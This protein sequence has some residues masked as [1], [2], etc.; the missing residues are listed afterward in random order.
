MRHN[1]APKQKYKMRLFV[2]FMLVAILNVVFVFGQ[3]NYFNNDLRKSLDYMLEH[4]DKRAVPTGLLRDYAVEDEDLDI[5]SGDA[6]LNEANVAT[7]ARYGNLL[8]TIGSASLLKDLTKD[9]EK[10]LQSYYTSGENNVLSLSIMLYQYARIKENALNDELIRYENGQVYNS[11]KKESPYQTAYAFAGCCLTGTTYQSNITFGLPASLLFSNCDIKKIEIDYGSG[12]QPIISNNTLRATL[13]KGINKLILKATLRDGKELL[14]HTIVEVMDSPAKT[15]AAMLVRADAEFTVQGKD[16]RGITTAADVSIAYATGRYS[17]RK[18]L[19]IVEGF[20]P[21]VFEDSPK[22][23]WNFESNVSEDLWFKEMNDKLGYDIVYVDW[24]KSEEYIQANANTLIEV[25]N[26]VNELKNNADSNEPNVIMGHSMGGLITRYALKTMENKGIRHQT[27]T[28]VSYDAPH[29][30]AHVPLGVLYGFHGMLSFIESRGIVKTLLTNNPTF[31]SYLNLGKSMAYATSAQ[32]M[33]AYFVDPAGHFNNQEHIHWQKEI[34]VLG[35]PKGDVGLSFTMLAVANGS[36][37]KPNI[38]D[39]YLKTDFS[40]GSDVASSFF[41]KLSALAVGIGLND[42]VSGFLTLLPG[43]TAINGGFE[44]YPARAAGDLVTRINLRYKKTFLWLIPISKTLFSY[45]RYFSGWYLFDTYPS[46]TC[47]IRRDNKGTPVWQGSGSGG[48][49]L[50]YDYDFNINVNASIPFIATSSALAFGDGLS[51]SSGNF[52]SE[53]KG[54]SSPF[55]E[56]YFTHKNAVSHSFFST[57]GL[58]WVKTRLSTS[59]IGPKVGYNEAKYSLSSAWGNITWS[60]NKPE[61]ASINSSGILSVKGKGVVVITANYNSQK[62]SQTIMVGMPRYIL[63]ASHETGGYKIN[64]ECIDDEYKEHLSQLNGVLKFNWGVK[65][66]NK[67]IRWLMSDKSDLTV[68]LQGQNE[69]VT[70]FLEVE[71]VLGNKSTLQHV[72]VNSQDIY[73]SAYSGFYIDSQGKLYDAKKEWD[74]YESSRVYLSYKTNLSDKYKGREWMPMA[75]IVLSPLRGYRE[76]MIDNEGPLVKD[77]LLES[78]FEFIKNNSTDNQ[79]YDYTLILLN[80]DHKVI[81]FIPVTLT[82]KTTI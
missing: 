41:P 13:K 75:A 25:I 14:A 10:S 65:Y 3:N 21:R 24:V 39:H 6:V 8:S 56:N 68:Q 7:L 22:G 69:S 50:I 17:L 40:G 47:G 60:S 29:L 35:F 58:D 36:Y 20:N 53:P 73:V 81:Q 72:K 4:I 15:R 37:D 34:N 57:D 52:F 26:R 2:A 77:I 55:C 74:L 70:V 63:S 44:I 23:L 19:I 67:E 12:Y 49:P 30:G 79:T 9:I 66:P 62:Y 64:A 43:R 27:S 54:L 11:K 78:E 71:D 80:F 46:S 31:S 5:F 33:L 32:Q 61:I 42:I 38:P 82:Y 51:S 1:N 76:I 59:I 16:Y 18:P 48:F 28:Y 45:D